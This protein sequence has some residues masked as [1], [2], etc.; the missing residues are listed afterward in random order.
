[1]VL[2]NQKVKDEHTCVSWLSRSRMSSTTQSDTAAVTAGAVVVQE[3]RAET[4]DTTPRLL[5][6]DCSVVFELNSFSLPIV[7]AK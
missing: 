6:K 4:I 2:P 3:G 7:C 5:G 1:M